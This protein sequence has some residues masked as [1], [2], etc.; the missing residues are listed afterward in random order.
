MTL[1]DPR[2]M[3]GGIR[4]SETC[5]N[6]GGKLDGYGQCPTVTVLNDVS[7]ERQRQFRRYGTNDDI[8]DGTGLETRWLGPYTGASASLIEADLRADYEDWEETT[9][10]PTWVHLVR[11]EVAEAFCE[12][13]P[14]RLRD[15]LIQ[16]AALCV[17]WVEK[18]DA[19]GGER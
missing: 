13:D 18:L 15:E 4:M 9:G 8:R 5:P 19:R 10:N 2:C 11:E 17:S 7:E 12:D 14:G 3:P 1:F 16:V 6:H